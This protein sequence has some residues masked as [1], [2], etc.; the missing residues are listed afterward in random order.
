VQ[1]GSS[2]KSGGIDEKARANGYDELNRRFCNLSG[3]V[4]MPKLIFIDSDKARVE[5]E[6]SAGTSLMRAATDN[7]IKGVVGE[8]GGSLSCATC[9]V[10]VEGALLE[11]IPP[12]SAS[13]DAMLD[14]TAMDRQPN[15]RLGCQVLMT[16]D[17]N[18][19]TVQVA[20]YQL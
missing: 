13:E 19:L 20:D 1:T 3:I 14:C 6:V 8:C 10:L 17:L 18:G 7:R 16:D 9:H 5:L 2:G 11:R 15:S 12:M 4:S